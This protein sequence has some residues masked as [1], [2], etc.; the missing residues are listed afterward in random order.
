MLSNKEVQF[1]VQIK[2]VDWNELWPGLLRR[3]ISDWEI[4]CF[5]KWCNKVPTTHNTVVKLVSSLCRSPSPVSVSQSGLWVIIFNLTVWDS[6]AGLSERFRWEGV[7]SVVS[8]QCCVTKVIIIDNNA[9]H[10]LRTWSFDMELTLTSAHCQEK[11]STVKQ[12]KN[13]YS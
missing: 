12:I 9:Q 3:N 6:L 4:L 11:H 2:E 1:W 13:I 8:G 5:E 10:R 7:V